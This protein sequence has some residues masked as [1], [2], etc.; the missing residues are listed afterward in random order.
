MRVE[1]WEFSF[2]SIEAS[3]TYSFIK[4]RSDSSKTNR[5]AVK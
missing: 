2:D 5:L 4:I 1:V 3:K